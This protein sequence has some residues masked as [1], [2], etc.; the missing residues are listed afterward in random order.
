MTQLPI[1]ATM[2]G[3]PCGIGPEICVKAIATGR[4]GQVSRP[5]L[6]GSADVVE[7]AVGRS[8]LDLNVNA[9]TTVE[10]ARFKPGT[11]DV[12]DASL[13]AFAD[14]TIGKPSAVCGAAV[15][16]WMHQVDDLLA[17][18]EIGAGVM[19]PVSTEALKAAGAIVEDDDLQP[20]NTW[21]FRISG[22]L[23]VIS[24]TEHIPLRSVSAALSVAGTV[25]ATRLLHTTLRKWG[26][27]RPRIGLAGLNPHAVGDEEVNILAPAVEAARAEGID[28]S[29]PVA[30][31]T[32]FRHSIEGRY[33]AIVALYHD[34]CHIA[35]KTA[36]FYGACTVYLGFP[37]LRLTIPHGTAWEIAGKG[38]ADP[39]SIT[40]SMVTA[41]ELAS[42]RGFVEHTAA[43]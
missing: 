30:P 4:P 36:A 20:P 43:D 7:D 9:T 17:S 8:G 28:I 41:G 31:D 24:L 27:E 15:T 35:M 34:Q 22:P 25:D 42:G 14:V 16:A 37:G 2:I 23:R 38:V 33:D 5:I 1:V 40:A 32:V 10:G 12:L 39:A 29:G 3:D 26:M 21:L 19:A 18:G 13:L 6:V 11:I